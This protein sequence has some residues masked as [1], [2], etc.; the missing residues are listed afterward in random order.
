MPFAV[1]SGSSYIRSTKRQTP[2]EIEEEKRKEAEAIQRRAVVRAKED[3][4]LVAGLRENQPQ[5]QL[6]RD[7]SK[8]VLGL[9]INNQST[10]LLKKIE[11]IEQNT[12]PAVTF[13]VSDKK[14]YDSAGSGVYTWRP[15]FSADKET[16]LSNA[17]F[18]RCPFYNY[19]LYTY[20]RFFIGT[21]KL[22]PATYLDLPDNFYYYDEYGN[23]IQDLTLLG[24]A[25]FLRKLEMVKAILAKYKEDIKKMSGTDA[26]KWRMLNEKID[27]KMYT[28]TD[29]TMGT[30]RSYVDFLLEKMPGDA[31]LQQIKTLLLENGAKPRNAGSLFSKIP[32]SNKVLYNQF[33]VKS[34][35]TFS[36]KNRLRKMRR[37]RKQ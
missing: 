37:S 26:T 30:P 25:V 35:S 24:V 12:I 17:L 13:S 9:I 23:Y 19:Y 32:A 6:I 31:N 11:E 2:E 33:T 14:K 29:R 28:K 34:K 22:G 16:T 1:P 5:Y 3:E 20:N 7:E 18:D 10:E 27:Y 36:R 8:I 21:Y 4:E 15:V